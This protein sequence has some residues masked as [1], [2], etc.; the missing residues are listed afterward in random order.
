MKRAALAAASGALLAAAYPAPDAGWLAWGATVPLIVLSITSQ[1]RFRSLTEGW[2]FGLAFQG[3]VFAWW[4]HLLRNY[5][6][7]S[8]PEAAGVFTILVGYLSAYTALFAWG[9]SRVAARHG[10]GAA[11]LAAPFFWT[12]LELARGRLL[13]GLPWALLGASQ[14]ATPLFLQVADLG[15][16]L[17]V[18]FVVCCGGAL[19]A[20]AWLCLAARRR[21][22]GAP[23]S[24]LI[25]CTLAATL[26]LAA[27]YGAAR[28]RAVEPPTGLL[29]VGLVQGNVAQEEKWAANARGRIL[30]AHIQ[31]TREAAEAGAQLVVWPESS[32]PLPLTSDPSYRS[33][34]EA[35]ARDL[36]IGLMVG[37]VHFE[38]APAGPPRVYNSAF[39]LDGKAEGVPAQRY[40]KIRLVPFGEYVPLRFLLGP[41]AKLVEEAS[42]FSPGTRPLVLDAGGA[43][44]APLV[45]YEAI[46]PELARRFTSAGAEAIVNITNDAFLGDTAGPR[47]HLAF[48]AIRAVE[49]RRWLLR[50]ANTGIS[51][52][53][54]PW[55]R[56]VKRSGYGVSAVIV[57]DTPLLDELTIYA[58]F[59]DVF[60][61]GC[62]I[63]AL[64]AVFFPRFSRDRAHG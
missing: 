24:L 26:L 23:A 17:A 57:H 34:L 37:S 18:S 61:W 15:G 64:A 60:G 50:A 4:F 59:G 7:L 12:A 2:L 42:D 9:A 58:R 31:A 46:F 54:D 8:V 10:A 41:V 48:A 45:C 28:L 33:L 47:Q 14:H 35:T 13:T 62:V 22:E 21:R 16:V 55:G 40:D 29:R 53:V 36:G 27:G 51:A 43:L 1:A 56:V 32:V 11:L 6:R 52:V 30:E 39:L 38:A 20:W 49:N 3:I 63:L 25:G 19:V 44:L 5:G